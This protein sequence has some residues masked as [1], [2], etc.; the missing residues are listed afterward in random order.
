MKTKVITQKE[1]QKSI[2]LPEDIFGVSLNPTLLSQ[3]IKRQLANRR[4]AIANT[5]TRGEV[6]GGGRKPFRQKGTGNARAGSTRSPLWIGGGV[7]FGPRT[8]RNF[9]QR[10]PHKMLKKAIYMALSE[11]L[12]N[13]RFIVVDKI[14]EFVTGVIS[15]DKIATKEMQAFLEHLSIEEGSILVLLPRTEANFELSAANLPYIKVIQIQNIN[16]F[17]L[18]KFDYV[19]TDMEGVEL[20]K[21]IFGRKDE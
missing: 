9:K 10:F 19:L 1:T 17:D 18:T 6:S 5:K 3:A 14:N 15:L 4:R 11:K 8:E 7:T 20:I 13:K 21:K 16:V 12:K 2:N